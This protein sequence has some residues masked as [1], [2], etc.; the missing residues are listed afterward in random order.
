MPQ[1]VHLISDFLTVR[2]LPISKAQIERAQKIECTK[3]AKVR[4]IVQGWDLSAPHL[5]EVDAIY[6]QLAVASENKLADLNSEKP[7][8][9]LPGGTLAPKTY[10]E[11]IHRTIACMTIQ[12]LKVTSLFCIM[13]ATRL[14]SG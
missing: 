3:Q 12:E 9:R 7:T 2:V 8:M 13:I 11:Y 1:V 6:H 5:P 10:T 4:H 14:K